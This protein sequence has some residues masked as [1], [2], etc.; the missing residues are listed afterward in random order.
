MCVHDHYLVAY[1]TFHSVF[2]SLL[3]IIFILCRNRR[4]RALV[5]VLLMLLLSMSHSESFKFFAF[6]SIF[7]YS[8][9]SIGR[10]RDSGSHS[11]EIEI[12]S[13]LYN[14]QIAIL[15]NDNVNSNVSAPSCFCYGRRCHRRCRCFDGC[16][17]GATNKTKQKT[18]KN[19]L[20]SA[21]RYIEAAL[22]QRMA[23]KLDTKV[24]TNETYDSSHDDC[25]RRIC[26]PH[27]AN[28]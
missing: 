3:F 5:F 28:E 17:S 11:I 26:L 22:E 12:K 27:I 4:R 14:K 13:E 25:G 21:M 19:R 23:F 6:S 10:T 2:D 8:F 16:G 7:F 9:R 18:E 15:S 20:D 1:N 24:H